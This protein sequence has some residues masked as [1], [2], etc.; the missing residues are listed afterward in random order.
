MKLG[1]YLLKLPDKQLEFFTSDELSDY[2]V[3]IQGVTRD[4]RII[5]N[6]TDFLVDERNPNIK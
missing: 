3:I 5:Y 6:T 4:G 2:M 1:F